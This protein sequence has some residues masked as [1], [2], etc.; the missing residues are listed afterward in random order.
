MKR[1]EYLL[2]YCEKGNLGSWYSCKKSFTADD[3]EAAEKTAKYL[4]FVYKRQRDCYDFNLYRV[5]NNKN[6]FLKKV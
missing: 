3:D 4:K 2:E 6:E 5:E 1:N